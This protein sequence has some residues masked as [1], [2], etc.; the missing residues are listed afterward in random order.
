MLRFLTISKF[1]AESGYSE[2]AIRSKIRDGIWAQNQVIIKAPDNRILIDIEGY[3]KWVVT[4]GALKLHRKAVSKSILC[5]KAQDVASGS[6]SS[7][8]PLI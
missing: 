7:P 5:I 8:R 3:E 6:R 4:V 1:S 2:G